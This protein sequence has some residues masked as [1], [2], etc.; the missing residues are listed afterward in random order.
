MGGGLGYKLGEI[1]HMFPWF[2][3]LRQQMCIKFVDPVFSTFCMATIQLSDA[4]LPSCDES[5]ASSCIVS[6]EFLLSFL[7]LKIRPVTTGNVEPAREHFVAY[8]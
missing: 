8:G 5:N 7:H 1:R 6:G 4:F 3:H 2:H